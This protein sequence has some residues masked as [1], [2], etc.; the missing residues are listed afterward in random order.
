MIEFKT[1]GTFVPSASFL[2]TANKFEII[3]SATVKIE[4]VSTS[5]GNIIM[6]YQIDSSKRILYLYPVN[7]ACIEGCN[8]KFTR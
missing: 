3:D 8:N 1:N 7:P 4:P 2:N 5:S 6:G